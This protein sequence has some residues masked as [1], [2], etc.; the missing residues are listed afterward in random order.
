MPT[1]SPAP[2][3]IDFIDDPDDPTIRN[4]I[5]AGS[6]WGRPLGLKDINTE[7]ATE[8]DPDTY[9]NANMSDFDGP[10]WEWICGFR[11]SPSATGE[12]IATGTISWTDSENGQAFIEVDNENSIVMQDY[13][14]GGWWDGLVRNTNTGKRYKI[15]YGQWAPQLAVVRD[16]T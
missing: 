12:Y 9:A 2:A 5:P 8:G 11:L 10:D 1:P 14:D 15:F 7:G 6:D 4:A 3:R 16:D 13:A